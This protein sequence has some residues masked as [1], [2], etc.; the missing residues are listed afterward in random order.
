[1][2]Y[3]PPPMNERVLIRDPA[4]EPVRERDEYGR[5]TDDPAEWGVEVW[6]SR[7]DQS[8]FIEVGE[9][10]RVRAG[11]SVFTVRSRP[12]P[13]NAILITDA[14]TEDEIVYDSVGAP[15]RRGGA[16]AGMRA[17]YREITCERRQAE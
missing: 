17:E 2:R 3:H 12:M 15:V 11:R 7:R 13:A 14:G 16:V 10:V 4:E 5:T 6:C 9:G 8:P 1:M